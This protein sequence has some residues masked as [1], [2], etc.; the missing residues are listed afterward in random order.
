MPK[1]VDHEARRLEISEVTAGLIASGGLEAATIREIARTSG[2]SKGVVEHYFENK[3]E[4]ISG[5]LGWA[6]RCYEQRVEEATEGLSGLGA[7]RKR[8]EATLPMDKVTKDE[9]KVRL[10]FWSVAAIYPE[11]RKQQAQRF[12]KAVDF[13]EQDLLSAIAQGELTDRDDTTSQA[14]HLLNITT[15]ICTAALH[16]SPLYTRAFLGREIDYL[17]ERVIQDSL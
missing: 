5:A 11:L 1:I 12:E 16:N 4:L 3:E 10:V 6:N 7:L 2:Y 8:I 13:Y 15:G 9:W 17:V 14:R